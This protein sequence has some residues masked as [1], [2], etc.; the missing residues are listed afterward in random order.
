MSLY[1]VSIGS[2]EYKV[3]ITD[4]QSK[5]NGKDVKAV[6]TKLGERGLYLLNLGSR[7]RELHVH[8]QGKNQY[9]VNTN[10]RFALA[11]VEKTNGFN[12]NR[13]SKNEAGNITAPISG[14]ISNVNVK[15]GDMV[16]RGDV[17]AIMES[18]KMQMLIKAPLDGRVEKVSIEPGS[19]PLKG[20]PLIKVI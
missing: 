16:S 17:L 7:K 19:Q 18:M 8:S 15:V 12:K 4:H 13:V 10:G 5:V 9:I 2:K 14:L 20:D 6:L 11:L 3:E 1:N